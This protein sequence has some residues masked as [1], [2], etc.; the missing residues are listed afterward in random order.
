MFLGLWKYRLSQTQILEKCKRR[1]NS[2][3]FC[4]SNKLE[5]LIN[6][7]NKQFPKLWFLRK[8]ILQS[9]RFIQKGEITQAEN[10][11]RTNVSILR[12][13]STF[14]YVQ[15]RCS[16]LTNVSGFLFKKAIFATKK[17]LTLLD[18]TSKSILQG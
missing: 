14:K 11:P 6:S 3:A 9:L 5:R 2:N 18:W 10:N 13:W 16:V 1:M 4:F 17:R 12:H 8:V 7:K 15:S